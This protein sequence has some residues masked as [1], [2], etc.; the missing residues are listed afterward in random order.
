MGLTKK[1]K[2]GRSIS[3]IGI[4][5]L[6]NLFHTRDRILEALDPIKAGSKVKSWKDMTEKEKE[7]IRKRYEK[8][9]GK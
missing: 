6:S 7:N 9:D 1:R 8:Q 5:S 4:S 2:G 3:F